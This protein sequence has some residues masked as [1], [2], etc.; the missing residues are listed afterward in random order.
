MDKETISWKIIDTYFKDNP[1]CMVSHHLGSFNELFKT[2]VSSIFHEN[3]P[4]RFIESDEEKQNK[5]N[6][7]NK[8]QKNIDSISQTINNIENKL[9]KLSSIPS[10]RTA[11]FTP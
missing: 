11:L 9:K 7:F 3:N 1:S 6:E 10:L 4:I 2:G 8:Q 5:R